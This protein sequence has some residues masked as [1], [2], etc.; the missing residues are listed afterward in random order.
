MVIKNH[1]KEDNFNDYAGLDSG[2]KFKRVDKNEEYPEIN[3]NGNYCIAGGG[4]CFNATHVE[5]YGV[6]WLIKFINIIYLIE[7][8]NEF[9]DFEFKF[10]S[11]KIST[12]SF[13][14]Y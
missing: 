7:L 4:S 2:W 3:H 9:W 11:S 10:I 8:K 1:R 12:F 13:N 5:F 14:F 6:N